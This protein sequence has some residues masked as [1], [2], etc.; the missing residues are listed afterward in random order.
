LRP[1]SAGAPATLA[2]WWAFLVTDFVFHAVLLAGWWRATE[3][4][5]LPRMELF[6]RIPFGYASFAVYCGAL[7][8]LLV[9]LRGP[10]PG[11]AGGAAFGAVS[12]LVY[13]VALALALYSVFRMPVSAPLVWLGTSAAGSSAAGA[14]AGWVLAGQRPWARVGA[15]GGGGLLVVALALV[16][17]NLLA[18]VP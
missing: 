8:W 4:Y 13:G 15:V 17:Q 18:A 7:V 14:A 16:L 9:R 12:G 1:R 6:G 2:A 10:A 3:A 5:W 11:A